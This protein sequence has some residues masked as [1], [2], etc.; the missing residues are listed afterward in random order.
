METRSSD[1]PA[2]S[3]GA[4]GRQRL[5]PPSSSKE[6]IARCPRI[7]IFPCPRRWAS[8]PV[9]IRVEVGTEAVYA[10]QLR[11]RA[12]RWRSHRRSRGGE[13][14]FHIVI[15]LPTARGPVLA[16]HR[17]APHTS[18]GVRPPASGKRFL[19]TDIPVMHG[20]DVDGRV[21]AGS[22]DAG[23]RDRPG[24]V[25][26]PRH[27]T[28]GWLPPSTARR[29]GVQSRAARVGAQDGAETRRLR[30]RRSFTARQQETG[31]W[32]LPGSHPR[33]ACRRPAVPYR[34]H[35]ATGRLCVARP[36]PVCGRF[37]RGR[38]R[39]SVGSASR[40]EIP[41]KEKPQI[42]PKHYPDLACLFPE[43]GFWSARSRCRISPPHPS[44]CAFSY[45]PSNLA[46]S[47][48]LAFTDLLREH[49]A[50]SSGD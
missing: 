15:P 25:T 8:L 41:R 14:P 42:K 12:G 4:S 9:A 21:G 30:T 47:P 45:A 37:L 17:R 48:G 33:R 46:G 26:A 6:Q 23:P 24:Q 18:V 27:V 13:A 31:A 49:H 35:R 2:G 19:V 34:P 28:A 7:P 5:E 11:E 10:H 40:F 50:R 1:G 43:F 29:R 38:K 3:H 44:S 39:P 36:L 20:R 22:L 16:D 32:F